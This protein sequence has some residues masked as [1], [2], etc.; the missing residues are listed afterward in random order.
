MF[1]LKIKKVESAKLKIKIRSDNRKNELK[2][3]HGSILFDC[4]NLSR[5]YEN[6]SE[7]S[8]SAQHN[9]LLS[10]VH[11]IKDLKVQFMSKSW[12]NTSFI[13]LTKICPKQITFNGNSIIP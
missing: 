8:S 7:N 13:N 11:T 3:F 12:L 5:Q 1:K 6:I 10:V 9:I 4:C 2:K